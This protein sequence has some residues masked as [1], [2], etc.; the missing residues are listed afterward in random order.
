VVI[1]AG[2]EWTAKGGGSF[3]KLDPERLTLE[4]AEIRFNVGGSR[5]R[6]PD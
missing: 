3:L 1:D 6:A 2:M 4:R 5:A